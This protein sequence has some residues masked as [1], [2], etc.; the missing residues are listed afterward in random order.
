[1]QEISK[2]LSKF[3]PDITLQTKAE[4]SSSNSNPKIT[5]K[6]EQIIRNSKNM[7]ETD[8]NSQ[9]SKQIK[10]P[11]ESFSFEKSRAKTIKFLEEI[12]VDTNDELIQKMKEEIMQKTQEARKFR[13]KYYKMFKYVTFSGLVF[14]A[15]EIPSLFAILLYLSFMT[16]P[17]IHVAIN[18]GTALLLCLIQLFLMMKSYTVIYTME[19]NN[20]LKLMRYL[21]IFVGIFCVMLI[22]IL[23]SLTVEKCNVIWGISDD[24]K[25]IIK[26]IRIAILVFVIIKTLFQIL[27]L[28]A[29]K[30]LLKYIHFGSDCENLEY[31]M[32]EEPEISTARKLFKKSNVKNQTRYTFNTLV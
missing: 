8:T 6:A 30:Q 11:N 24:K 23:L 10:G 27:L 20:F 12:T 22:F 29:G 15:L 18:I 3:T 25:Q 1:M 19:E 4:N 14:V 16:I 21:Q 7:S 26:N 2:N 9:N 5:E 31:D 28:Y 32:S 13:R 17:S